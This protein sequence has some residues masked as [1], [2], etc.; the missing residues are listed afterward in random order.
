MNLIDILSREEFEFKK[1][2]PLNMQ[3]FLKLDNKRKHEKD[4]IEIWR[5]L[6]ANRRQGNVS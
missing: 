4:V 2:F 1:G 3:K 6:Q 5:T